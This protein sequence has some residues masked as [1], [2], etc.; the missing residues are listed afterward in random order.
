VFAHLE[1]GFSLLSVIVWLPLCLLNPLSKVCRKSFDSARSFVSVGLAAHA[2]TP[3]TD[4]DSRRCF[5][6]FCGNVNGFFFSLI[7]LNSFVY[8]RAANS[9]VP[10]HQ[11]KNERSVFSYSSRRKD[12]L[13]LPFPAEPHLLRC[14]GS[15]N[16]RPPFFKPSLAVWA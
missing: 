5:S 3:Q 4:L 15:L 13:T 14:V 7:S 10:L 12:D 11:W 1:R 8:V 6:F 2:L 16:G 9:F